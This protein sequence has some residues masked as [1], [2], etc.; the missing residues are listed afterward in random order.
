MTGMD[1]YTG[2]V[3]TVQAKAEG[4]DQR[5]QGLLAALDQSSG[6]QHQ[7]V[8]AAMDRE[9]GRGPQPADA[10]TGDDR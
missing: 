4:G 3:M 6:D 9:Y 8:L 5:A 1:C 2:L 7:A 10:A